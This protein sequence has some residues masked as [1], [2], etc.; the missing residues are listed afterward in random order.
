M[1][2]KERE[3]FLA[4]LH[5]GVISIA[6]PGRG[7]LTVPIW[8]AYEP[9]GELRVVTGR[10]SRKGRLLCVGARLSLCAQSEAP[11]YRYVSVEGPVVSVEPADVERDLR[12]LARRYLGVELADA[13]VAATREQAAESVVVRIRPER[14]LSVD[15]GK[16]FGPGSPRG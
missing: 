6:E 14:W 3:A 2:A 1:S 15:Y 11:P 10:D 12:P 5:V 8:Y 16:E 9:G 7:P 13:Y 4:G